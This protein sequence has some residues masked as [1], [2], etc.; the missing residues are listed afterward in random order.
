MKVFFIVGKQHFGKGRYK[1][2]A[3]LP[4]SFAN[5]SRISAETRF[6]LRAISFETAGFDHFAAVIPRQKRDLPL[7]RPA[8]RA[9]PFGTAKASSE[10]GGQ[11]QPPSRPASIRGREFACESMAV[12]DWVRI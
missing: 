5:L 8:P 4:L 2:Q 1:I 9:T 11:T 12:A 3:I 10:A 7:V 6:Y